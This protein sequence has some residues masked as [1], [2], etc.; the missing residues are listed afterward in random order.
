VCPIMGPYQ[1][2]TTR[3]YVRNHGGELVNIQDPGLNL[4]C[5][6]E[7]VSK[8]KREELLQSC[9]DKTSVRVVTP[10]ELPEAMRAGGCTVGEKRKAPC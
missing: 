6:S 9:I 2:G 7:V 3:A 5:V 10:G 4:L 1:F 8:E